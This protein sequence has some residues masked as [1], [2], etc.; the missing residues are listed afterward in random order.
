MVCF[1][2]IWLENGFFLAISQKEIFRSLFFV[3]W[4]DPWECSIFLVHGGRSPHLP[5]Y[6]QDVDYAVS[7]R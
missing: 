3:I 4:L 7:S 2:L 5:I 1:K 6:E